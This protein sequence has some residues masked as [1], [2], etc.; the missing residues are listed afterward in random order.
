MSIGFFFAQDEVINVVRS[1]IAQYF[2]N[3]GCVGK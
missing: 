2:I 1:S 3:F